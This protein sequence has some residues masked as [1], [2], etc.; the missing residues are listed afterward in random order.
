VSEEY[1]TTM[2]CR[3]AFDSAFYCSSLGSRFNDIYRH[4]AL[5][6]CSEHWSDFWFCM[7]IKS[8]PTALRRELVVER[9]RE[10]EERVRQGANSE[11]V[12]KRR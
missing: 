11:D 3:T 8:K 4:G 2:S 5:R 7:R 1:P 6:S 9:Y 12:W 10:K